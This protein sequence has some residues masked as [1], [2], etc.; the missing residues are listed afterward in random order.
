MKTLSRIFL[1]VVPAP[2]AGGVL[3]DWWFGDVLWHNVPLHSCLE[4]MGA[5]AALTVA[6]LLLVIV[7]QRGTPLLPVSASTS[8]HLKLWVQSLQFDSGVVGCE[9]P[10]DADL[11]MV[12]VAVPA[13][14][15]G[16]DF[17]DGGDTTRQTLPGQHA[18]F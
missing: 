6:A 5:F 11:A 4:T 18:Q 9:L 14:G 12:A 1:I 7:R 3:A 16:C 15:L 8:R 2:I 17:C 10:V 13:V